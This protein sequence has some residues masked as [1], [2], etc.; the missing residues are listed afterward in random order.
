[1]DEIK[2][3]MKKILYI[4]CIGII[5]INLFSLQGCGSSDEDIKNQLESFDTKCSNLL[6]KHIGQA[7]IIEAKVIESENLSNWKACQLLAEVK[8]PSSKLQMLIELP[9][10]KLWNNNLLQ[11]GGGG[12]NGSITIPSDNIR[13]LGFVISSTDSGHQGN[14]LDFS[15][16]Q[17]EIALNNFAYKSQPIVLEATTAVIKTFYS[18][19]LNKKYFW[20]T[21][22]GGREALLQAQRY[23]DNYDGI[24]A[25]MPVL[26]YSNVIQRGIQ[27]AQS[28][29]LNNGAG[30]VNKEKLKLYE[31]AQIAECDEKDGLQDGL[32]ANY[33]ACAWSPETLRCPS[34]TDEGDNCLSDK[35]LDSI[36]MLTSTQQLP[37]KLANGFN[38]TPSFGIGAESTQWLN[39]QFGSNKTEISS[40]LG[41]FSNSYFKYGVAK[42]KNADILNYNFEDYGTA[43]MDLSE[44]VNA[45]NPDLSEFFKKGGKLILWHGLS[46]GLVPSGFS[47]NYYN[48]VVNLLGEDTVKRSMKFY[49]TPGLGHSNIDADLISAMKNW[50]ENNSTPENL[51]ENKKVGDISVT[52]PLCEWPKWFKYKG[53]GDNKNYSNFV[54]VNS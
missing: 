40:L 48:S 13:K 19:N 51:I 36:K 4:N 16:A 26:D 10:E 43:W 54:C 46:D 45:T 1:M 17:D 15:F 9:E 38:A 7:N 22:T 33:Q 53:A 12:F 5:F 34:G 31:R 37:F 39:L 18:S 44:K 25:G 20:G 30:W 42:D 11:L 6:N 24:I 14:S 32:I 50:V 23:P 49:T 35:Q 3:M 2:D 8:Y 28:I 29:F 41:I 21:S 27:I 52:R 47:I